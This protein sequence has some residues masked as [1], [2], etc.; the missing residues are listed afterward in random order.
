MKCPTTRR[1]RRAL[2]RDTKRYRDLLTAAYTQPYKPDQ[3][4]WKEV[5]R[6]ARRL[7]NKYPYPTYPR[8]E[9]AAVRYS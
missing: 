9:A 8:I 2:L 1:Q 5:H 3:G 6:I 7:Q 4:I